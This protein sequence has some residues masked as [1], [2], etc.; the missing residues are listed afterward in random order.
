MRDNLCFLEIFINYSIM[1]I[2]YKMINVGVIGCGYW[3]P[4]I[5][6][7]FN[8]IDECNMK[9]CCDLDENRL[10]NI[11]ELYPD[12]KT[13]KNYKDLINNK[14]VDAIAIA[15]P[16][17]TH[18]NF[19]KE[20][21]EAGKH[22]LIEKPITSTSQEAQKLI[23]L[24][25]EKQKVLMVDHTF[26]YSGPVNK[27]KE[28]IEKDELGKIYTIDL[29]RVNLGLFQ[30]DI[31]VI[32]DLT[33]HDIS[34]LIYLLKKS[35]VSVRAIAES[36]I[37]PKIEDSAYITLRFPD[38]T[39]AN[40]HVSW[41]DPCKIRRTTIVGSK[42][43]LVYD[44]VEINEKIK[45]YDKGVSFKTIEKAKPKHWNTY[46]EFQYMYREGDVRVPEID[47]KEPLQ[48]MIKHFLDCIENNKTPRSDG[49]SGLQV[50]KVIE[51]AQLSLKQNGAE[52]KIK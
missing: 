47:L 7:N 14:D 44:D 37:Q 36:Y 29:V 13:T 10:K 35:P 21:L 20:A 6:R 9:I 11:K 18:F 46:K 45:I 1:P 30:Q 24:A 2:I 40:L 23:D 22:V 17:F 3:G 26:E 48:I 33:P 41:L 19:A 5:I 51:A 43:M 34:I 27:I 15:T 49:L 16:V 42:K 4:N 28:L 52:V 12:I 39:M 25:K 50:I 32:W 31:N 38:Q 8:Q